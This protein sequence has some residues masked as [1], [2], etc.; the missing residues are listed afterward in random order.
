MNHRS[1]AAV[2]GDDL[3]R[4]AQVT[5]EATPVQV[6][7]RLRD[8]RAFYF[9]YRFG[10]AVLGVGDMIPD[11]VEQAMTAGLAPVVEYGDNNLRGWLD[12]DE[13]RDLFAQLVAML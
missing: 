5:C 10:R 11:A 8:G 3:V 2:L 13:L 4:F 6:E 7:G 9:R 1:V 12:D